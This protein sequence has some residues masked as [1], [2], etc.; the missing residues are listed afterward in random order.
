MLLA[1]PVIISQLSQVGMSFTDTVMAGRLGAIDLAAIAIGGS[2]W[3]PVY[4]GGLGVMMAVSPMAAQ[5]R[6]ADQTDRVGAVFQQT[7]LLS[8]ALGIV[9]FWATR[10]IGG[11]M[12]LL[13]IDPDIIPLTNDYLTAV[14][15]GMPG[16]YLYLAARFTSE[17]TGNT[18]PQMYIQLAG[19]GLNIVG[20]YILMFGKWGAPALGA[21]GAG[22]STA[23]VFWLNGILLWL[24][25]ASS[26]LYRPY[27]LFSSYQGLKIELQLKLLRIG[28]PISFTAMMEVGLFMAVSLLMGSLGSVAVAAHQIALNYAALMFMVPL[29]LSMAITVRVG[30]AK[31]AGKLHHA[32][33]SGFVGMFVAILTMTISALV[34]VSFPNTII[35]MYTDEI[36]VTELALQLLFMAA[37]FQVSDGLQVS[38]VGA[39]RG[40][41]DTT[42]PMVI[43]FFSYWVIGLPL[44]YGLGISQ[45]Q[46]PKGLWTGLIIGLTVAAVLL[47]LRFHR[48]TRANIGG[49]EKTVMKNSQV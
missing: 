12:A 48:A 49:L 18:K 45:S 17:G 27:R 24:Y 21:E 14:A 26:K 11:I 5:M 35:A 31:G 43:T 2:L 8:L 38:A 42:V 33:Y 16:A 25:M 36:E 19:L 37:L 44:A 39:L 22:W 32:R 3:L 41:K 40:L 34:M 6:G 4:V 46:G 23:M 28:L 9:G 15:W 13:S 10:S 7:V 47:S 20:N 1:G 30:H 29:G